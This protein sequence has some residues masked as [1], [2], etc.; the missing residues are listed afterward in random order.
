MTNKCVG[1]GIR[2][3]SGLVIAD[4]LK[5]SFSCIKPTDNLVTETRGQIGPRASLEAMTMRSLKAI[6]ATK[7]STTVATHSTERAT[8]T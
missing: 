4:I 3:R 5:M 8:S 2:N 6:R 1:T 7:P